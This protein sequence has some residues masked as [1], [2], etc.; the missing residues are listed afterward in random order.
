MK[1][2]RASSLIMAERIRCL[3]SFDE[4]ENG[5]VMDRSIHVIEVIYCLR[6]FTSVEQYFRYADDGF[7]C[8]SYVQGL[9]K[10]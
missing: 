6:S 5:P 7:G 9:A 3:K 4:G 1:Q 8:W 10:P 2:V